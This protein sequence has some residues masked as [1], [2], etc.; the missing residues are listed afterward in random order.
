MKGHELEIIYMHY[1]M[2]LLFMIDGTNYD[3]SF[4]NISKYRLSFFYLQEMLMNLKI[5]MP[6]IFKK[7]VL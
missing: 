1:Y 4:S 5:S 3:P 7:Y 2:P 6:I